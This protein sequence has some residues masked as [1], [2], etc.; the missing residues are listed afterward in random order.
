MEETKIVDVV[1]KQIW[2]TIEFSELG[3]RS[4]LD[5]FEKV[6]PLYAKVYPEAGNERT[7]SVVTGFENQLKTVL[8]EIERH[9][10]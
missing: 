4:L 9:E 10:P 7:E 2:V 5:F 1:P 6:I 8:K 3:I